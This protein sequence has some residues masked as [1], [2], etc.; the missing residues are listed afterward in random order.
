MNRLIPWL[1]IAMAIAACCVV[2]ILAPLVKL[3]IREKASEKRQRA[4]HAQLFKDVIRPTAQ[5]V[6]MFR[7][8]QGTLPSQAE[9]D[10]YA[11]NSFGGSCIVIFTNASKGTAKWWNPGVDFELYV[12]AP[13]WNLFY[14][15]WDDKETKHWTH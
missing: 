10:T 2:P 13:G 7:A 6:K 14:Q 1:C 4:L 11:S 9:L 5:W 8:A 3:E 12:H 15:S